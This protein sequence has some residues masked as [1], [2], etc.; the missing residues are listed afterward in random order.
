MIKEHTH[1]LKRSKPQKTTS[2]YN[3]MKTML[4]DFIIASNLH[5]NTVFVYNLGQTRASTK[6]TKITKH[7]TSVAGCCLSK[8]KPIPIYKPIYKVLRKKSDFTLFTRNHIFISK[9]IF[10]LLSCLNQRFFVAIQL[11][12]SHKI[13]L[14]KREHS[15]FN[16]NI[17]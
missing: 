17:W 16:R 2:T 15:K 8:P 11:T 1:E 4:F 10:Y 3:V 5:T 13:K 9:M 12:T 7:K 6:N 14:K